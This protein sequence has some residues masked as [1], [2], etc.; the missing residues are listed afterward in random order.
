MHADCLQECL[1]VDLDG[2]SVWVPQCVDDLICGSGL[3]T[4]AN[5]INTIPASPS[6]ATGNKPAGSPTYKEEAATFGLPH[7]L[8]DSTLN[9]LYALLK[10]DVL[11]AD[12]LVE[13][14]KPDQHKHS[15]A[16][17]SLSMTC[18]PAQAHYSL[19][20]QHN[21]GVDPLLFVSQLNSAATAQLIAS[22]ATNNPNHSL[23]NHQFAYFKSHNTTPNTPG[24]HT[25]N[26]NLHNDLES[27]NGAVSAA[28]SS[29]LLLT[30]NVNQMNAS[31]I[32]AIWLDKMIRAVF[33]RLF[34]Q[35][36][37]GYRYCLLIIRINP[38][39]VI[40]FNKATFL[41]NHGLAENEF[42]NRL[43]DSMSF[44][45]FIEER[46]PSFRHCDVFDDLYADIQSQLKQELEQLVD[47]SHYQHLNLLNSL[48][49]RHL[50]QIAEKLYKYEYP[51]TSVLTG[52]GG[53]QAT[54][55][56]GATGHH[57]ANNNHASKLLHQRK[58]QMI[59][60]HKMGSAGLLTTPNRSFS[61]IK[62]PTPDAYKR[63]HSETFPV[64]DSVEIQR[65]I[66][67]NNSLNQQVILNG[68][69]QLIFFLV[70][71]KNI[72]CFRRPVE[73]RIQTFPLRRHCR[74]RLVQTRRPTRAT[75][76]RHGIICVARI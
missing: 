2:A 49:M 32:E 7:F 16:S 59:S 47:S 54:S 22:E 25:A 61:K 58:E 10:P 67:L 65:L 50:R 72:L 28:N 71:C 20:Q 62:L 26:T 18:P 57:T 27:T 66:N 34:A 37:A 35:L 23:S 19:D 69:N 29:S 30:T 24:A 36:F 6:Y 15:F 44:Q 52:G 13:F 5:P 9:L 42:M 4:A 3:L 1:K 43:L 41:G 45:R 68:F 31:E 8:Y 17:T 75:R 48:T 60:G 56:S 40:C 74:I 39:P 51:Q 55:L 53:I 70:L 63:I 38:K 64:L 12:E 76:T 11:R 21:P 46:G 33:V 14:C 73:Y